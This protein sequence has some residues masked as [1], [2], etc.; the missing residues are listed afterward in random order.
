MKVSIII[1]TYNRCDLVGRAVASALAQTNCAIDIIVV[2][3][4]STDSTREEMERI[5]QHSAFPMRYIWKPN[6]GC[7]SARNVGLR[8]ATGDAFIFLDSDDVL[9]SDAISSLAK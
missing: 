1:P 9:V 6:G 3:D 8:E 4:G 7:A 2:D 5:A